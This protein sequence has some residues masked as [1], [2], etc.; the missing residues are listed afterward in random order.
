MS[1]VAVS[2][3]AL[4]DGVVS[5]DI[6]TNAEGATQVTAGNT[7]VIDVSNST[8][9]VIVAIYG[10]GGAATATVQAGDYPLAVRAGLGAKAL[11]IPAS[12]C[13]LVVLEGAR[14]M[15]DDGKI[16]IDIATN[17]CQVSANRIPKTI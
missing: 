4:A 5:A 15:H 6:L 1:D 2:V 7:A 17:T 8:D 12:D 10:S 3:T 16:R 13:L 11:T 9:R 14:Y